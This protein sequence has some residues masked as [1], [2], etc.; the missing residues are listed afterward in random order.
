M[1]SLIILS[2]FLVNIFCAELDLTKF[3]NKQ[4]VIEDLKTL[5]LYEEKLAVA[6]EKFLLDNFKKPSKSELEG[7]ADS[8]TL[9]S[10]TLKSH[11]L[12]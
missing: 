12:Y 4:M 11:I 10:L 5:I 2:F 7:L 1:R 8:L 9:K 6:Y 3:E